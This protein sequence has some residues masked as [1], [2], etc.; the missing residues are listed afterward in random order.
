LEEAGK[1]PRTL[2]SMV[3][4]SDNYYA[5]SIYKM[6]SRDYDGCLRDIMLRKDIGLR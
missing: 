5:D 6:Y 3:D 2:G 1:D 4:S